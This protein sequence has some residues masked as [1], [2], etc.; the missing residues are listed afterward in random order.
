VSLAEMAGPDRSVPLD[1]ALGATLALIAGATNAGGFL[2]VGHYTSH[3]TG[4]VSSLADD[5]ALG[6][7]ALV[8][9]G[10]VALLTF[11]AGAM[12][13][14]VLVNW[15]RRQQHRSLFALP[16]LLE[17]VLLILFGIVGAM[18]ARPA[19]FAVPVTVV[20]L[21]FLMGLQNAVITKVS[22][23]EIRTT[24]VTGLVTDIG[25]ELGRLIYINRAVGTPRVLADRARL[26]VQLLLFSCFLA[27]GIAGALSFKAFGFLTVFPLA[28]ILVVI[29][30][31]PIAGDLGRAL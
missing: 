7:F 21:C 4:V 3:M 10:V 15:G 9:M 27:G 30:V 29:S 12:T 11:L 24:H 18:V 2:A 13:T 8:S 1:R 5:L 14:S 28:A 20:V 22:K 26:G 25:I 16:L 17:A 6:K 31:P 23:A 19:P